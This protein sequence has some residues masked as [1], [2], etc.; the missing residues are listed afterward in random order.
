MERGRL[1]K[2]DVEVTTGLLRLKMVPVCYGVPA[3][4]KIWGSSILSG[5]Q[6]AP[7]LAKHLNAQKIIEAG[8]VEG[9]FTADPKVDKKA[10]LIKEIN[11]ANYEEIIKHLGGSLATDVT[12]GM[13]QKYLEL[14]DAAKTGIVCQLVHFKALKAALAGQP[15]GTTI[16]YLGA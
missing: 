9:I 16:N 14:V 8:D 2:M 7:Y 13:K 10:T 4:D 5:D 1:V 15:V 3:Y 6:I 12:G 11:A